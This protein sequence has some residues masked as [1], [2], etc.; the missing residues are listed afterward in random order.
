MDYALARAFFW[1]L[2]PIRTAI[3]NKPQKHL[4]P[5]TRLPPSRCLMNGSV[6]HFSVAIKTEILW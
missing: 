3:A 5:R 6:T 1:R 4:L 2:F